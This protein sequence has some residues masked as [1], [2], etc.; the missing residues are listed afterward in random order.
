MSLYV[1]FPTLLLVVGTINLLRAMITLKPVQYIDVADER[2]LEQRQK[3]NVPLSPKG[4]IQCASRTLNHV[5]RYCTQ[6]KHMENVLYAACPAAYAFHVNRIYV[7][8]FNFV[9]DAI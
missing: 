3:F 4:T 6:P 9:I 7:G 1:M 5:H 8:I 2:E